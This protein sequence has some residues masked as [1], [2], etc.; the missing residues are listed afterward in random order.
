MEELTAKII[1]F[2]KKEVF[3]GVE[4]SGR[5]VHLSQKDADAL[6][7]ENYV[8]QKLKPLSQPGQFAAKERVDIVTEKGVIKNVAILGPV[9]SESQVE[10]SMTDA[11]TLGLNPPVKLSGD[12]EGSPGI[13]LRNGMREISISRGVIIAKRHIHL[14]P[15]TAKKL[16]LSDKENVKLKVFSSRPLIFDDTTVRV[17]DSFSDYVHIDYDEANACGFKNGDFA[18]IIKK[19]AD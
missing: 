6:F 15:S 12:T 4:A 5:H 16:N 13:I 10:I 11:R 17:S 2:L 19:N 18:L 8:F 7:G 3:I 14:T 1:A 9:R